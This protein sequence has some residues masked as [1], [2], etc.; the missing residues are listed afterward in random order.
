[1]TRPLL[2]YSKL[3]PAV[4]QAMGLFRSVKPGGRAERL[5]VTCDAK[6][7]RFRFVG[8]YLLGVDDMRVMQGIIAFACAQ[9]TQFTLSFDEAGEDQFK[10]IRLLLS[11]TLDVRTTYDE[12]ARTI[13]YSASG[14]GADTTIRNALERLFTVSVFIQPVG[15]KAARTFEAGH[16]FE[17]LSSDDVSKLVAV[18]LCPLLAFAVLGGPGTYMRN[19]LVEARKLET[20]IARLLH[21]HLTWLAPG[22]SVKVNIETLVSYVYG[23]DG[24]TADAQRKR[25]PRVKKGL[26]DLVMQ[27]GWTAKSTRNGYQISRPASRRQK[28]EI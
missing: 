23:N 28:I 17:R 22:N 3:A 16:L 27:L 5:E 12:L 24:V 1:M 21:M 14:S 9:H 15:R 13:G 8:P 26:E 20:D 7:L 6:D 4:V 11:H 19:D 10:K 2:K 25:R 18:K